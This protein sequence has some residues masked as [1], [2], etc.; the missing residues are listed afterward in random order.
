MD[1]FNELN[2]STRHGDLNEV[3]F[4]LISLLI[5]SHLVD[6]KCI[7]S[8]SMNDAELPCN[9]YFTSDL[10]ERFGNRSTGMIPIVGF[11][12]LLRQLGIGMMKSAS[13][14][15]NKVHKSQVSSLQC[16]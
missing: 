13:D 9:S 2:L 7:M 14:S 3:H 5:V 12:D 10:V 1:V 4:P 6:G 11:N 15:A 16:L 8:E